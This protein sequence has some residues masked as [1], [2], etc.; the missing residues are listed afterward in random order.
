MCF[1]DI[2]AHGRALMEKENLMVTQCRKGK[3][4]TRMIDFYKKVYEESTRT[5]GV[6]VI[7]TMFD[8]FRNMI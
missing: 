5:D 6:A 4:N 1:I 3:R 8:H 2:V 7:E